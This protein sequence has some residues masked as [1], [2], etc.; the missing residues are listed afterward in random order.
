M[1]VTSPKERWEE[2]YHEYLKE[3]EAK[4]LPVADKDDDESWQAQY[5]E[6]LA[7]KEAKEF[8]TDS[9]RID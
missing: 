8:G 5:A 6:Y 9:N 4:G 2:Q 3:K 7:E 1:E